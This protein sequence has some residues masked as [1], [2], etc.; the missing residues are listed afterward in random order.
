METQ[1]VSMNGNSAHDYA[2]LAKLVINILKRCQVC[3]AL[4]VDAFIVAQE[5]GF[6]NLCEIIDGGPCGIDTLINHMRGMVFPLTEHESKEL[7]RQCCRPGGPL[8]RQNGEYETVCLATTT[9]LDTPDSDGP[10]KSSL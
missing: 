2:L 3:D 6:D 8:S 10:S 4:R 1:Q 5:V 7:F 9:L